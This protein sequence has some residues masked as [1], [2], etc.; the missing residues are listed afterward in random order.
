MEYFEGDF[1]EKNLDSED[2]EKEGSFF[3]LE[4]EKFLI[5]CIKLTNKFRFQ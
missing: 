2:L 1:I 5:R 4:D 3:E